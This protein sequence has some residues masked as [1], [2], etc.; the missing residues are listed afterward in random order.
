MTVEREKAQKSTHALK[1]A[2][3]LVSQ[4]DGEVETAREALATAEAKAMVDIYVARAKARKS[5]EAKI[6]T[7][8]AKSEKVAEEEVTAVLRQRRPPKKTLGL[9]SSKVMIT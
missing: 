2:N 8:Q 5:A 1:A 3:A 9:A 4:K 7:A 6:T